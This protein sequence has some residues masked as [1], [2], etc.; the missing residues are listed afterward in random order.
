MVLPAKKACEDLSEIV[1]PLVALAE[2]APKV[3][4]EKMGRSL[5]S[6]DLPAPR[7]PL[8]S[9]DRKDNQEFL[10]M[11]VD[12]EYKAHWDHPENQAIQV[13]QDYLELPGLKDHL[14]ALEPEAP[15]IIVRHRER[16]LVIS[17]LTFG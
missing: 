5:L 9:L 6:Q 14:V 1:G 8:E 11:T 3:Q 7:V 17:C 16:L 10:A 2:L 15:A 13:I 4:K 12:P